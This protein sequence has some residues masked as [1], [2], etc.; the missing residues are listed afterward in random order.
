M[1]GVGPV[2]TWA[3]RVDVWFPRTPSMTRGGD[4][5]YRDAIHIAWG[6]G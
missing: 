4:T 3:L 1:T 2:Y 6:G 5:A